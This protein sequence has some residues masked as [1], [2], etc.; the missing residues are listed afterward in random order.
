A[1]ARFTFAGKADARAV[2]DTCRDVDRQRAL[3]RDAAVAVAL[4]A[5]VADR[6]AAA[7]AGRAG[8]FDGEEALGGAHAAGALTGG[9]GLRAGAGLCARA[10]AE[11]AG[12]R[13][14]HAD[15]RRLARIGLFQR[16]FHIVA[17]IAAA[18]APAGRA[19]LASATHHFAKNIL[20]DVREAARAETGAAATHATLLEGGVTVTVVGRALLR[21]LERFVGFVE[22]LE[23]LLCRG[24]A[25]ILVRV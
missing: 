1:N 2:L 17:K 18:L 16:D 10:G 15:L 12:D 13:G 5:G 23:L 7:V 14:R 9:A 11:V 20:E 21:V 8:A 24:V 3:F 6:L 19:A 25:R 22:F 4:G